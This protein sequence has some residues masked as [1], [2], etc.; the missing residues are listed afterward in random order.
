MNLDEAELRRAAGDARL[1]SSIL[2]QS[3]V[4]V[5]A[6]ILPAIRW[7]SKRIELEAVSQMP[8]AARRTFGAG[9]V[10]L[11]LEGF[12]AHVVARR[13]QPAAGMLAPRASSAAQIS[14]RSILSHL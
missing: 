4:M 10:R 7:I 14:R 9:D 2:S 13:L 1:L 3:K 8:K 12:G 6:R 5:R 11:C